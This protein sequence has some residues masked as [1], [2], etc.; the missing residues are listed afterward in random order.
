[1]EQLRSYAD[2]RLVAGCVHCGST[3]ETRDHGPSRI[4]LDDP[5]PENLPCVPSCATCNAGFSL[6]EEYLACLVEC[7]LRGSVEAVQR[8][9]IKRVL[10]DKPLLAERLAQARTDT[11]DGVVIFAV[12]HDRANRV[13]LKLAR[14][15]A[16][17]ELSEPQYKAPYHIHYIPLMNLGTDAR[18]IFETPPPQPRSIWPELG[19][20]AMQ[21][22]LVGNGQVQNSQWLNVQPGRY[23]YFVSAE[24]LVLV[25]FV[26]SEYL[27]CEVIWEI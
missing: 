26:L 22:L 4:L 27:A 14:G 5:Y 15:H 16:A 6:D 13:V 17:F 19:S 7:A 21:R 8:P 12:E 2:Q 9:K 18:K 20:R 3:A 23:R 24:D 1:M 10:H 25:R 11:N